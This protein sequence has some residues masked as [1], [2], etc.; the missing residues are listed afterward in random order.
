M[1]MTK[2]RFVSGGGRPKVALVIAQFA[3]ALPANVP[4]YMLAL[5]RRETTS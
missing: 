2:A 5:A 4:N 3:G 1:S